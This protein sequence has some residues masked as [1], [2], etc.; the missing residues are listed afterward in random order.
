MELKEIRW[1]VMDWIN[2]AQDKVQWKAL[3]IP[4]IIFKFHTS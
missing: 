1:E 4:V 2:L 3:E